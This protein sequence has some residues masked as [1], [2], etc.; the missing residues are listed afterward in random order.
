MFAMSIPTWKRH[1]MET[2]SALLAFCEG[3]RRVIDGFQSQMASN[4]ELWCYFYC[5]PDKC[6]WKI[7]AADLRR[8]NVPAMN[9]LAI[10]LQ[11]RHNGRDG[12]SNHQ[13]HHCLLN[14]L[15]R[16]R[17]KKSSKLRVTGLCAGNSPVTDEFPAQSASNAEM[18]PFDDVIMT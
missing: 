4:T 2:L 7:V 3:N 6:S 12:V 11:W 18:F 14:C 15:F 17:S 13:P 1:G 9:A 16:R 5:K 10:T 8:H